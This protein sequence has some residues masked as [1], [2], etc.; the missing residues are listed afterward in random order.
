MSWHQLYSKNNGPV[1]PFKV[2]LRHWNCFL[3]SVARDGRDEHGLKIAPNFFQVSMLCRQKITQ[4]ND[5]L[6]SLFD[7]FFIT[8]A[9]TLRTGSVTEWTSK[10]T[11]LWHSQ[12]KF[13]VNVESKFEI[14]L[15][16]T[17]E[18]KFVLSKH[19]IEVHLEILRCSVELNV[20]LHLLTKY[21]T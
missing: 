5:G 8:L 21:V 20:A 11:S 4:K 10:R 2:V 14:I 15:G 19:L 16:F 1:L 12:L 18:A 13:S 7:I 3:S 17:L 9:K 6:Y